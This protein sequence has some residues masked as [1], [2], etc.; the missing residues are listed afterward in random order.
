MKI[1]PLEA[2]F[3]DLRYSITR[4]TSRLNCASLLPPS[5]P[6]SSYIYIS[7][8][9][10]GRREGKERKENIKKKKEKKDVK[11]KTKEV[12]KDTHS[13]QSPIK[14]ERKRDGGGG[15]K[16]RKRRRIR[17]RS[18]GGAGE[19]MAFRPERKDPTQRGLPRRRGSAWRRQLPDAARSGP[20]KDARRIPPLPL[21]PLGSLLWPFGGESISRTLFWPG[22]DPRLGLHSLGFVRRLHSELHALGPLGLL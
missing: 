8:K 18:A 5:P 3:K 16:K 14:K 17:R 9:T 20:L 6:P 4:F 22:L 12:E 21:P 7:L 11:R 19:L 15:I 10:K 1:I 13:S 2:I